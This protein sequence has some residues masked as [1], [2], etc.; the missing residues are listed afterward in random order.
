MNRDTVWRV[1]IV[2][3]DVLLFDLN[4]DGT[5]TMR[6]IPVAEWEARAQNTEIDRTVR[7]GVHSTNEGLSRD[8]ANATARHPAGVA[9]KSYK[10]SELHR[11]SRRWCLLLPML[12]FSIMLDA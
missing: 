10:A 9:R 5:V 8:A 6:V 3:E 11:L 4:P 2:E 7:L 12:V 1:H